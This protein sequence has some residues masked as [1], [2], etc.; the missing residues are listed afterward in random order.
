V[1]VQEPAKHS[2]LVWEFQCGGVYI[3]R[4]QREEL[5]LETREGDISIKKFLG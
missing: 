4:A 3:T 5:L 2:V 1:I